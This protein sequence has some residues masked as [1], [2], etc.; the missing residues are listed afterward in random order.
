MEKIAYE[1]TTQSSL[2]VSPRANVAFYE[3]LGDFTLDKVKEE[4]LTGGVW[5]EKPLAKDKL[6][7]IYPFYQYGEYTSYAPDNA[8]YYLPGSSVKGALRQREAAAES[9]MADDILIPNEHIV[10]RNLYKVQHIKKKEETK[11]AVFFENVGVEMI[12]AKVNLEGEFYLNGKTEA[13]EL[14]A[15]ANEST[16]RKIEQMLAYL[17][18]LK[19]IED[20]KK[21][22][23]CEVKKL[24][25]KFNKLISNLND[26]SKTDDIFLLGG[27][28]GLLHTMEVKISPL[29]NAGAI[30]IDPETTLPHG[31]VIIKL[32]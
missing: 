20:N 7:V 6:K 17:R 18:E 26:L 14:L 27:Y 19:E 28:K 16:K 9:F 8:A 3:S 30:F 22:V 2:I 5:E 25:C 21:E 29:E 11:F 32:K 12:K 10:L 13:K 15:M 31:L 4:R 1:L 23:C 24:S